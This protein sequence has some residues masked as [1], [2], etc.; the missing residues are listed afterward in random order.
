M[1]GSIVLAAVKILVFGRVSTNVLSELSISHYEY[2]LTRGPRCSRF[3]YVWTISALQLRDA[4]HKKEV[5]PLFDDGNG[6]EEEEAVRTRG[7]L[8]ARARCGSTGQ[9]GRMESP[10]EL[11]GTALSAFARNTD[12]S[13]TVMELCHTVR[14]LQ[15][16]VKLLNGT[17]ISSKKPE[18]S[19]RLVDSFELVAIALK[20]VQ[21]KTAEVT[22]LASENDALR[23]KLKDLEEHLARRS[24]IIPPIVSSRDRTAV[25]FANQSIRRVTHSQNFASSDEVN[26]NGKRQLLPYEPAA[27]STPGQPEGE[28]VEPATARIAS[29]TGSANVETDGPLAILHDITVPDAEKEDC[30]SSPCVSRKTIKQ[31]KSKA[32]A[33]RP[34]SRK[35]QIA[36]QTEAGQSVVSPEPST[37]AKK[38]QTG[39]KREAK[40]KT[41]KEKPAAKEKSAAKKE[42]PAAK[43]TTKKSQQEGFG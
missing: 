3:D 40:K 4:Y 31:D 43:A 29:Q 33:R 26:V 32:A 2:L 35:S 1:K 6:I 22:R 5:P 23:S 37:K 16:E 36:A 41:V 25:G 10:K 7:F 19:S 28:N 17:A 11:R 9:S 14:E 27:T 42:K 38:K 13:A 24:P 30:P 15:S 39:E 12:I 20:E 21:T 34:V 18:S 8:K